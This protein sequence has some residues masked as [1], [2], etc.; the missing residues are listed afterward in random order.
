MIK[1]KVALMV[2]SNAM[3]GAEGVVKEII[4][5]L[6]MSEIDLYMITN[7][8]IKDE[9]ISLLGNK[10]VYSIGNLFSIKG[11]VFLKRK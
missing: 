1:K 11:G 8:E 9:F 4:K 2:F 3:G 10:K 5:N 7:E 6:S